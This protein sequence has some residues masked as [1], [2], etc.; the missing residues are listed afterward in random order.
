MI[1]WTVQSSVFQLVN[2]VSLPPIPIAFKS[3]YI[4]M[5]TILD[6]EAGRWAQWLSTSPASAEDLVSSICMRWRT[7]TCNSSS[8]RCSAFWP[9]WAVKQMFLQTQLVILGLIF[10]SYHN[11]GVTYSKDYSKLYHVKDIRYLPYNRNF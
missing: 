3:V 11:N 10:C 7:I 6:L 2:K 1:W 9:L 8:R 5:V 4:F